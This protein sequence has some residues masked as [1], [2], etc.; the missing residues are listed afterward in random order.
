VAVDPLDGKYYMAVTDIDLLKIYQVTVGS[1]IL[2]DAT[3]HITPLFD[4][5]AFSSDGVM[6]VSM[7][8]NGVAFQYTFHFPAY[9]DQTPHTIGPP[10]DYVSLAV[11]S[12]NGISYVAFRDPSSKLVTL[13]NLLNPTGSTSG[14]TVLTNISGADGPVYGLKLAM[15][16]AGT[17]YLM[18]ESGGTSGGNITV[19]QFA[20]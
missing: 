14:T 17:L 9:T 15:D 4:N 13:T 6:H 19:K 20:R 1:A 16:N 3:S 11:D 10:G 8:E 5:I 12:R 2:L 18:Y 7:Q